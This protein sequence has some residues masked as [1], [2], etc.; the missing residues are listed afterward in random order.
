[1]MFLTA[2]LL[3]VYP[4]KL[5]SVMATTACAAVKFKAPMIELMRVIRVLMVAASV[6]EAGVPEVLVTAE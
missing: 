5:G 2:M 3:A 1:M 4:T 6:A